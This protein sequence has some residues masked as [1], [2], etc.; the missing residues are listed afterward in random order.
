MT[1]PKAPE[2]DG[3]PRKASS[4]EIKAWSIPPSISA[5]KNARGYIIPL[6][7][8]L[9]TDGVEEQKTPA[10][11]TNLQKR[12]ARLYIVRERKA[13]E[14]IHLRQQVRQQQLEVERKA[15]E[16][17][18]RKLAANARAVRSGA[19]ASHLGGDVGAAGD[20]GLGDDG[21][22]EAR[23]RRDEMR[24]ER[25]REREHEARRAKV[26]GGIASSDRDFLQ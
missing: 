23:R 3:P 19:P 25:K 24:R 18:L 6:D 9:V 8:R 26:G 21:D 14:D 5:W 2:R 4:A 20:S 13:R 17:E 12:S 7:K 1:S 11:M 16:E 10:S 15:K 22:V